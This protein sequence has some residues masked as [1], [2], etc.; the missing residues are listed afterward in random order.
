MATHS[1]I[2]AWKIPWTEESG[3]LLVHGVTKS[4]TWLSAHTHTH[5]HTHAHT[6]QHTDPRP[7]GTR[8]WMML[9]SEILPSYLTTKQPEECPPADQAPWNPLLQ[10]SFKVLPWKPLGSWGLLSLSCLFSLLG[11]LL[12]QSLSRLDKWQVGPVM[13][14][15]SPALRPSRNSLTILFLLPLCKI[16]RTESLSH[17]DFVRSKWPNART[18][19]RTKPGLWDTLKMLSCCYSHLHHCLL[20]VSL[21][22][23]SPLP[24]IPCLTFDACR[25]LHIPQ[26]SAHRC[27]PLQVFSHPRLFWGRVPRA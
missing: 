22:M 9:T 5:T 2:L 27:L 11:P 15:C 6:H 21:F 26:D 8:R 14:C 13:L 4:W 7:I 18:V 20:F 3:G 23:S 17:Q 19:L 12:S 1:S 16:K 24:R 25:L 10:L